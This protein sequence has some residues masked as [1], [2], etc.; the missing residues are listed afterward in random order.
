M[1]LLF[2]GMDCWNITRFCWLQQLTTNPNNRHV[3]F[4]F[5]CICSVFLR[6]VAFCAFTLFPKCCKFLLVFCM[7][8]CV[9]SSC[10]SQSQHKGKEQQ[11][12]AHLHIF[13]KV[14]VPC[15]KVVTLQIMVAHCK[16]ENRQ[17]L[18]DCRKKIEAFRS[19][20]EK[21]TAQQHLLLHTSKHGCPQIKF[22]I[23]WP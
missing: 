3:H 16:M 13:S 7:F 22:K 15:W 4:I 17:L 18:T 1:S 2:S 9:F 14:T 6:C 23:K 10:K 8:A 21:A 5:F 12:T 20:S 19:I 11:E